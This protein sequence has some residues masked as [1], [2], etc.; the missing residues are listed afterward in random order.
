M[1]PIHLTWW[2]AKRRPV[3]GYSNFSAP[4]SEKHDPNFGALRRAARTAIIMPGLFALSIEV[5]G[6]AQV[7]TFAAFGSIALLMLVDFPGPMRARLHA[8]AAFSIV[9]VIF[10]CLGAR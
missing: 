5:I 1:R 4:G 3:V 6:N 8:Q 2:P 9:G 10:V 7:A